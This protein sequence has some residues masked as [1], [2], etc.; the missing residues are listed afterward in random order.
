MPRR[1]ARVLVRRHAGGRTS[2]GPD[3]LIVEEPMEIRLDDALVTTTMRTP[4]HDFELAVGLCFGDGL[5]CG[6]HVETVAYCTT[7]S[8]IS[9][10]FNV[11]T[12]GTDGLAPPAPARL[13]T[14]TSS[15]GL[16]GSASIEQLVE[17]LSPVVPEASF[18]PDMLARIPANTL[19]V[20][21]SDHGE[22]F[23]EHGWTWHGSRSA[24]IDDLA[25]T[26]QLQRAGW[27]VIEFT[28]D[29]SVEELVRTVTTLLA[30]LAS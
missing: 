29:D 18:E 11:V 8:V 2:S 19:V 7:G 20:I 4:G 15:C 17:R 14:V 26:R 30:R 23:E 6:A 1:V 24:R 25:R 16:C 22:A 13:G 28:E 3:E 21:F 5:L 10:A 9:S 27:T 12:V